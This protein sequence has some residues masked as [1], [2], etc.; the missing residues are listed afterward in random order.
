MHVINASVLTVCKHNNYL[1]ASSKKQSNLRKAIT[2]DK[3]KLHRA[4]QKYCSVQEYLS[5]SKH[6]K[7]YT[8]D[9]MAGEFSWSALTGMYVSCCT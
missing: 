2:A 6:T 9:I 3:S 8:N 1:V 7:I 5:L 4:I